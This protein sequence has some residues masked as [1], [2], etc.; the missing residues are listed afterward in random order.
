MEIDVAIWG[1]NTFYTGFDSKISGGG[2]FV[3]SLETLPAGHELD[4]SIA[5]EGR[6]IQTR[7]RVEFTRIDNMVNP[8]CIP[9]AGIKLLDLQPDAAGMI[10]AFFRKRPPLFM[11]TRA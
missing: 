3:T 8:E 7:G 11:V 1:D 10:E 2:L 4:L 6:K 9:G 5:L